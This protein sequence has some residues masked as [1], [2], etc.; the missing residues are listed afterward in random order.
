MSRNLFP[1]DQ[2]RHDQARVLAL[3]DYN[4]YPLALSALAIMIRMTGDAC[5]LLRISQSYWTIIRRD[6]TGME[7]E[8]E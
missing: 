6:P 7:V 5:R 4:D 3:T 2:G 8:W 1:I